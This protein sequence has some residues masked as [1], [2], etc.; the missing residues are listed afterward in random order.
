MGD[1]AV[2]GE[3]HD[4]PDL[5]RGND[6]PC[7]SVVITGDPYSPYILGNKTFRDGVIPTLFE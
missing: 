1:I 5:V 7:N 3:Y 4:D 6:I 2:Q